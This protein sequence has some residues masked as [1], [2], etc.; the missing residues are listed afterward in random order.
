MKRTVKKEVLK[1][2]RDTILKNEIEIDVMHVKKIL[3]I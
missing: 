3:K 1:Y 2:L